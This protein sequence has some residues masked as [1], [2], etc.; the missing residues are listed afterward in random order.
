MSNQNRARRA[1]KQR[2][3]DAR[4]A[5]EQPREQQGRVTGAT[6][7]AGLLE[8]AARATLAGDTCAAEE[9][10]YA[11]TVLDPRAVQELMS[12]LLR[13]CLQHTW[14]AGWQPI[15][16]HEATRRQRT[17]AHTRLLAHVTAEA[18]A[19]TAAVTV[20][21]TWRD[22]LVAT[23]AD[24][25]VPAGS[26]A[27]QCWQR[28][29]RTDAAWSV[30]LGIELLAL[31][32]S[33]P[34]I[35]A[36]LP[37]P[38]TYRPGAGTGPDVDAK[39]LAKVRAL[40][41]KAESTDFDEEAEAL[42]AKAQDLMA[43]HSIDQ[44]LVEA[45]GPAQPVPGAQRLWLDPPYA[46]A[47]AVLAHAVA[48]ANHCSLVWTEGLGYVTVIG[49]ERDRRATELLVTSLLVQASR[50]MLHGSRQQGPQKRSY[51]QSF[52]VA[53]AQRIGERL[54]RVTEHVTQE[55]G[56]AELV[57]VLRAHDERVEQAREAM[58]PRTTSRSVSV[59]S[60]DG[61]VAGRAAADQA[62]LHGHQGVER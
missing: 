61:Y 26:S 20:H 4:R 37:L 17:V 59:R 34:P 23:G 24:G 33:L 53:Y 22:Q 45:Q 30:A 16:V 43:R 6:D 21:P 13:D 62:Q 14:T 58:F 3:R 9:C 15:D 40:L 56:G 27:V 7:T 44:I 38:G 28:A 11:T 12:A 19:R 25:T 1:A 57:P 5:Q 55:S 18:M 48:R 35:E 60:A 8:A 36:L 2:Q 47:K 46:S 31:L 10:A 39:V 49:D 29:E 50:A 32:I 41:A 51:R 42:S 52:L 54:Q